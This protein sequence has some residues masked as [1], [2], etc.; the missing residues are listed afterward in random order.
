MPFGP[1]AFVSNA[2]SHC[3]EDTDFMEAMDALSSKELAAARGTL[4]E[5]DALEED[6]EGAIAFH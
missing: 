5:E 2:L 1:Y 3:A 6:F 4:P